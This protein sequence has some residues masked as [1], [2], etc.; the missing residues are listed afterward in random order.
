LSKTVENSRFW[1]ALY[2]FWWESKFPCMISKYLV[3]KSFEKF[4]K[5][6]KSCIF[7]CYGN[8]IVT[9][10]QNS[11]DPKKLKK[12][13]LH[14]GACGSKA[15]PSTGLSTTRDC[16]EMSSLQHT[17]GDVNAAINIVGQTRGWKKKLFGIFL[18]ILGFFFESLVEKFSK[19]FK[20]SQKDFSSSYSLFLRRAENHQYN[21]RS[22]DGCFKVPR[23]RVILDWGYGCFCHWVEALCLLIRWVCLLPVCWKSGGGSWSSRTGSPFWT[24]FRYLYGNY[25]RCTVGS[26]KPCADWRRAW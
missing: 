8:N 19:N 12:L 22:N 7:F 25:S 10:F 24:R 16:H 3:L 11:W 5:V 4:W 13:L 15:M 17:A 2:S 9:W 26:L 6:L 1:I 20:S 21:Q 18:E 23:C 14:R